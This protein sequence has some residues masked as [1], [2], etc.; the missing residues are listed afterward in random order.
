MRAYIRE[1]NRLQ[2]RKKQIQAREN[3]WG[4]VI[5]E[6]QE[7]RETAADAESKHSYVEAELVEN[8]SLSQ[9]SNEAASKEAE[10]TLA[11]NVAA[12]EPERPAPAPHPRIEN[13][14]RGR[15]QS[16][17]SYVSILVAIFACEGILNKKAFEV[18]KQS[19]RNTWMMA[20][21]LAIALIVAAHFIGK[22]W[23]GMETSRNAVPV[24]AALCVFTMGC[25]I[26]LGITRYL[27]V[28]S[29]R[30]D[31]LKT[32]TQDLGEV[33][34]AIRNYQIQINGYNR[35]RSLS[36]RD[37]NELTVLN[38]QLALQQGRQGDL[39]A[40]V[41]SEHT[42]PP[43][44]R[45]S[46]AIPLFLFINIFLTGVASIL[47]YYFH[48]KNAVEIREQRS[49]LRWETIS[50]WLADRRRRRNEREEWR[51]DRRR[52]RRR[53]VDE[54]K[55]RRATARTEKRAIQRH[56]ANKLAQQRA[57]EKTEALLRATAADQARIEA[58]A[59]H[60]VDVIANCKKAYI[61]AC[62]HTEGVYS[63]AINRYWEM[64]NAASKR[65]WLSEH[66]NAGGE[67]KPLPW[68]KPTVQDKPPQFKRPDFNAISSE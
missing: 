28:D 29:E 3:H 32:L 12:P 56:Q 23:R 60:I 39:R 51:K 52:R 63:D 48:E 24:F 15:A 49:Q 46:Y 65:R 6:A 31:T 44:D 22:S 45:P 50:T 26:F 40:S 36:S 43:V 41:I 25:A 55:M 1:H 5:K 54:E 8:S 16:A 58:A 11:S 30:Q 47:S 7:A 14:Q 53:E 21:G 59:T 19:N 64:N 61:N 17:F 34:N 62:E 18:F 67:T 42:P 27:A 57:Q 35:K 20:A 38:Q 37:R 68:E 4:K 2:G 9:S 13:A 66:R 33:N 10:E